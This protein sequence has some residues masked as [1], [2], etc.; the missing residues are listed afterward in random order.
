[1]PVRAFSWEDGRLRLLDQRALPHR[2]LW[3]DIRS[4]EQAAEAIRD[5]AVRGAPAIGIVAAYG[6]ALAARQGVP[7]EAASEALAAARPTAVNLFWAIERIGRLE[8]WTFERV[9]AEAQA[10]EE[11][12]LQMNLRLAEHGAALVPQDARILTI[13]NTGSLATSGHGTA[14]GIIRTAHSQGKVRHVYSCETRPRQQGLRLTAWELLQDGIPFSS[15]ADGAAAWLMARGGVDLVVVGADRIAANGDT[16]N[17]IGTYAL[18]VA[19]QHHGIPFV[20]AAPSSTIDP[21]TPSGA[22]IPIEERSAEELTEVDGIRVAPVGCPVWNPA[23]D[24]TPGPLV[25]AI[26][27]EQ[28]VFRPPFRFES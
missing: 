8:E 12:D 16:A 20:V 2:E 6:L 27:T 4:Y 7:R 15:I 14:L 17:K 5:M 26:V 11:E 23:F 1:M 21:A 22:A 25:S 28:G 24:V 9:L 19:S 13:C 18:A 3:L 10:I